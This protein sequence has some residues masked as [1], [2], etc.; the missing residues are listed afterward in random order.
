MR[1]KLNKVLDPSEQGGEPL[2]HDPDREEELY[3]LRQKPV[4]RS[5]AASHRTWEIEREDKETLPDLPPTAMSNRG[6]PYARKESPPLPPIPQE[7]LEYDHDLPQWQR[8][9]NRGPQP[10]QLVHQRLLNWAIV[11]PNKELD[12]ALMSCNR[13]HQV[14]EV[15]LSIWTAQVYKRYI[16]AR[17]TDQPDK[18]IERLF[19][20]PNMADAINNAVFNGRHNDACGMLRDLW[21]PFGLA[22]DKNNP[23]QTN[24]PRLLVVLA[25]HR[26]DENHWV[27]HR[28]S[29]PDGSLTTYDTYPER[30]LPDGRPLGWWFAIRIAWPHAMYPHPDH[31][32]Q[33][34]VR[35]HRPLQLLC[36]NSVAAAAIWRNIL[37]G[38]KP[39]RQVDLERLRD[40]VSSEVKNLRTRKD[41]GRLSISTGTQWDFS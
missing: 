23:G 29:L 15:A 24:M 14:D 19:V 2:E 6:E 17:K 32:V 41:M 39:E 4:D 38:S 28:F 35:L 8:Q 36:D 5:D 13:G 9:D 31:L 18:P 34:M 11:W 12:D 33:K 27:V 22:E 40:L 37:M 3:K 30:S 16:R 1:A 20:P 25:R 10:W 7:E 26:R 21:A